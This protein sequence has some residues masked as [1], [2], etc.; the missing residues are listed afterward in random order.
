MPEYGLTPQGPNIKRL[1]VILN[2]MHQELS[3][4]WGVNTKQNPE[5]LLNHLLTNFADQLAEL[6][7]F[8]EQVYFS[9]YPSTA[10]G[11]SLDNAAHLHGA[12][13]HYGRDEAESERH[14]V[15]NHL[16]GCKIVLSHPLHRHRRHD[17]GRRHDD[18]VGYEPEDEPVADG[19][20]AD[21]P[22]L[23]Q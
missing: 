12:C 21:F 17:A 15:G 3:E 9:Q 22:L 1:D 20:T 23:V 4:K 10:E 18:C 14:L 19:S 5:S 11:T 2:E 6:W 13:E 8:G 7:E 16:Y